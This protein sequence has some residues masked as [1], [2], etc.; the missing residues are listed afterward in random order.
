MRRDFT[1]A[2]R[3]FGL[4][5]ALFLILVIAGVIAAMARLSVTQHS[6]TSLAIQQARAYQAA[7][8]GLEW[9][10]YRA[11]NGQDCN[12]STSFMAL[13]LEGYGV[14]VKCDEKD[15]LISLTSLAQ[16]SQPGS[17]DHVYRQL[18]AV[19]EK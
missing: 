11:V 6:T 14:Q 10:I 7:Q 9:G 16:Y 1:S 12:A 13:G 4:V 8:A 17:P 5:A 15:E 2:Q 3:G 18:K 19:L